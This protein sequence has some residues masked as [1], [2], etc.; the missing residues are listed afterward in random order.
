MK[1]RLTAVTLALLASLICWWVLRNPDSAS[2]VSDVATRDAPVA[3]TSSA[4]LPADGDSKRAVQSAA[5][6]PPLVLPDAVENN[7]RP[8]AMASAESAPAGPEVGGTGSGLTPQ[9]VLENLRSAFRQYHLRFGA[10]PVGDNAEISA[11]LN[12]RN[13]RQ[14]VFVNPD[15]GLRLNERG[16]LVDNW[17]TPFFFHQLSGSEMEIY[18]AGPDRR[19]WSR[20]DL[21]LK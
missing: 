12:G 13:A 8:V 15:D 16:E 4:I 1:E 21:V 11:S 6:T 19:M 7:P 14:A 18:S 20:D 2:H 5:A 9:T 3:V 17:G 10:N